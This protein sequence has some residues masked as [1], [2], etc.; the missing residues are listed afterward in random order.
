MQDLSMK[1]VEFKSLVAILNGYDQSAFDMA[2]RSAYA[3]LSERLEHLQADNTVGV[4]MELGM[5]RRRILAELD[6]APVCR[7]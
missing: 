1:P 6:L 4:M 5:S 3:S 2:M 7:V